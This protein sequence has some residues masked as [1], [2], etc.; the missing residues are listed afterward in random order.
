MLKKEYEYGILFNVL[1]KKNLNCKLPKI[2]DTFRCISDETRLKMRMRMLNVKRGKT[3]PHSEATKIKISKSNFGKK[4]TVEQKNKISKAIK[5]AK[6]GTFAY[7]AKFV[8]NLEYGIYYNSSN[9]AA[10]S[11]VWSS[12]HFRAMLNGA[13]ENLTKFIYV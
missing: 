6:S 13:K 10:L 5:K 9:E 8:L 1:D 11:D 2:C 7:N 3:K 12:S 4:R